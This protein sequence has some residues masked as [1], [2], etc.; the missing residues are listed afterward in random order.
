MRRNCLIEGKIEGT[1]RWEKGRNQ[2][3]DKVKGEEKNT[4]I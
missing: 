2:L 4:E 3:L 1:G